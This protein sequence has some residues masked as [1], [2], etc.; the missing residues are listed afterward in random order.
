MD[1]YTSVQTRVF[2]DQPDSTCLVTFESCQTRVLVH[3]KEFHAFALDSL[4]FTYYLSEL[5]PRI[6]ARSSS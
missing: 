6:S 5:Y 4:L 3:G 2:S 1:D